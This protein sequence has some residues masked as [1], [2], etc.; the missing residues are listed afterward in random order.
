M[1]TLYRHKKLTWIDLEE[2]TREDISILVKDHNI[3]PEW[4]EELLIPSERAKINLDPKSIYTVLHY[5]NHPANSANTDEIEIDCI[6]SEQTL[7]TAHYG[8]IDAFIEFQKRF[9][10]D[11][12]LDRLQVTSGPEL[13]LA[14]NNI[15]YQGLREELE[16]IRKEIR[17]IETSIFQGHEF[18][19][20]KEISS[21]QRRLIDFKQSL[22]SHKIILRALEAQSPKLFPNV[23]I[24]Q[25]TFY[26]EYSRVEDALESNRELLKEL[27][28]TNDSLLT[29]KNNDV[30]KKLTLM[31]FVTFPLTLVA[32]VL[33]SRSAPWIFQ[34]AH[35]FWVMLGILI[36]L[37][38]GMQIYFTYKKWI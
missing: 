33:E 30:T 32:T 4:A 35:G 25:E 37:F 29:A 7:I 2:P 23:S 28:L 22:H 38:L 21:L 5:P 12:T 11:S 19:M 16:P 26:R 18:R 34:G 31:A 10:V 36:I 20:V 17:K 27:R 24:N 6:I 1:I 14:I 3:H 9:Q 13:F 8:A 15:L